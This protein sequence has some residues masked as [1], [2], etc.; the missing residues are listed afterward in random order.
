MTIFMMPQ[1]IMIYEQHINPRVS[2]LCC[3]KSQ[4]QVE[5]L[6]EEPNQATPSDS[7]KPGKP[8]LK[9][10]DRLSR[11]FGGPFNDFVY[12]FRWPIIPAFVCLG[13]LAFLKAL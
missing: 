4:D 6:N 2:R 11:F 3:K 12:R 8:D 13:V 5:I 10:L 1:I 7:A 9:E